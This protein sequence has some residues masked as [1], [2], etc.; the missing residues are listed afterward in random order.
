MSVK[1]FISELQGREGKRVEG[2]LIKTAF[3]SLFSSF[4]VFALLYYFVL[5]GTVVNLS[6]YYYF[7]FLS[8]LTY[9]LLMP[10]VKQVRAFKKFPCMTGMMIGMTMGM[11]SGMMIGFFVGASNGMFWGSV[12]GMGIGISL[13]V[14]TGKWSGIMGVMEGTMAGFMGGLM[15]AMTGVMMYNDHLRAAGVIIFLI[16]GSILIGLNYMLY[17]ETKQEERQHYEG[18]IITVIVSVVLTLLTVWMIVLGP[19]SAVF[20]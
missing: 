20:A 12:F 14:W 1:E 19:K 5:Q 15:G 3:V 9:A 7:I 17:I 13:G 16:G 11:M 18:D 8:I 10:A 6:Q 4:V 2:E